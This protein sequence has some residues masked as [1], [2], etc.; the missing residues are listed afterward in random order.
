M[1]YNIVSVF[2]VFHNVKFSVFVLHVVQKNSEKHQN[3]HVIQF[4]LIC[5]VLSPYCGDGG[6]GGGGGGGGV[7][8]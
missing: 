8:D 3:A 7:V 1:D 6:G 5:V 4:F 2:K